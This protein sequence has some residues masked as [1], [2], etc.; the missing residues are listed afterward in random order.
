MA[1][2]WRDMPALTS[3]RA[4]E[5]TAR[6][7]G[8]SQAARALNVT[9]AAV[10]QQVRSLEAH[11]GLALARREGRVL[12]LTPAGQQLAAVLSEGFGTIAG[13]LAALAN[14]RAD[15]PVRITLTASFAAQWL[16]PRLRDF[17][18]RHPDVPVSLHPDFRVVDLRRDGM[19]LGIR[20]GR[21]NWPGL[22]ASR[23]TSARL[24]AV[25]APSLLHG[26]READLRALSDLPWVLS[27]DWPEQE[28]WLAEQ[29]ISRKNLL[30][31][32][33]ADEDLALA[34]TRQGLGLTVE[35][36]ALVENDIRTGS[37]TLLHDGKEDLPAYFVVTPKGD[38]RKPVRI[39]RDWLIRQA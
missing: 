29:G 35:S 30:V 20:Y 21:G 3:L 9:H 4:F 36:I 12:V 8:F 19:D 39:F 1:I 28:A 16:M 10:A 24:V 5:A 34:A 22:D 15:G 23:L 14:T 17:W 37:L 6:L 18:A 2:D 31:S 7:G 33:F 13:G 26:R 11:V 38:L 32:E 25:G 27:P